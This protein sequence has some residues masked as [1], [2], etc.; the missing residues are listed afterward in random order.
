MFWSAW[1]CLVSHHTHPSI[2]CH[3]LWF[4]DPGGI[5]NQRQGAPWMGLQSITKLTYWGVVSTCNIKTV[6]LTGNKF[7]SKSWDIHHWTWTARCCKKQ[8]WCGVISCDWCV[9]ETGVLLL[10]CVCK[11]LIL[12]IGK[13]KNTIKTYL[14]WWISSNLLGWKSHIFKMVIHSYALLM[15][16]RFHNYRRSWTPQSVGIRN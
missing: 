13:E 15:K 12:S 9:S 2:V 8:L 5:L 11:A 14:K 3:W 4:A 6:N 10:H 1:L 16:P 7:L